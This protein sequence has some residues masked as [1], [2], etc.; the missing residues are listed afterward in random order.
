MMTWQNKSYT[1]KVKAK[2]WYGLQWISNNKAA[3]FYWKNHN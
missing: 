2:S 1:I 3:F